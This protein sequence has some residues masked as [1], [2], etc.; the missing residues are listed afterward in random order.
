MTDQ[1]TFTVE[2]AGRGIVFRYPIP[3]QL[4]ILRRRVLRSQE[5]FN[6]TDDIDKKVALESQ[7]VADTL[8]VIETL[9]VNPEDAEFLEQAM[10]HGKVDH[11]QVM[12]IL[13]TQKP[14]S[15]PVTRKKAAAKAAPGRGRTKR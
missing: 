11:I 15:K 1:E 13:R 2:F 6:G 9:I 12:D 7:M 14:D 8:N 4:I 5:Q 10:L 3:A